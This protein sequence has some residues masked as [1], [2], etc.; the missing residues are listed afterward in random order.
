MFS[1]NLF[2]E[3]SIFKIFFSRIQILEIK[4]IF[5]EI[6]ILKLVFSILISREISQEKKF[7][8]IFFS[9][10]TA[11]IVNI[12]RL[13]FRRTHRGLS[14]AGRSRSAL[15][16]SVPF[17]VCRCRQIS[18]ASDRNRGDIASNFFMTFYGQN[19]Q[20]TWKSFFFFNPNLLFISP[21]NASWKSWPES[22]KDYVATWDTP[23]SLTSDS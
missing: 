11:V 16:R 19:E 12:V 3:I 1:R 8:G 17:C 23:V 6:S 9:E 2:R 10:L 5:R 13:W 7:P 20:W 22:N 15:W 4:K 18:V 21:K 14:C